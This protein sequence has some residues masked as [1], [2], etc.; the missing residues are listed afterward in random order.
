MSKTKTKK[1]KKKR[2]APERLELTWKLQDLPTAQHRAGLAGLVL[3]IQSL[4]SRSDGDP[5]A[6]PPDQVPE[7]VQ[8]TADGAVVGFTAT[9]VQRLMDDLYDASIVEQTVEK[10]WSGK[11]PKRE[12]EI[13]ETD[14]KTQKTKRS[15]RFIYDVYQPKG[16][17]LASRYPSMPEGSGW[18]KLWRDMIWSIPR[19]VPTTRAPYEQRAAASACKEGPAAW[20]ELV[21]AAS[22]TSSPATKPVSSSLWL[23]AQ[24]INAEG[25]D[26]LGQAGQNFLLHFWVL[27]VRVSVP[28]IIDNQGKS[29][30]KGYVLAFPEVADLESFVDDWPDTLGNLSTET[31]GYRPAAAVLDVPEQGALELLNS[32][33]ALKTAEQQRQPLREVNAVEFMHVEKPGNSVKLYAS[34]RVPAD[35]KLLREY[36][37]IVGEPGQ[38][39]NY[40][41]PLFR[42]ALMRS[43]LRREPWWR[44]LLPMFMT[45]DWRFF[46]NASDTSSEAPDIA[47][48][49]WFWTDVRRKLRVESENYKKEQDMDPNAEKAPRPLAMIINN[50]VRQYV[51]ER[52][53]AR[54]GVELPKEVDWEKVNPKFKEEQTHVAQSLF[55][56]F[57][58]RREQAFVDHFAQTLFA[59]KQYLSDKDQ[60]TLAQALTG[61]A[62]NDVK[63]LTLMALSANS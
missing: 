51:R 4:K 38:K 47:R 16:T 21:D 56:E 48:L 59:T 9:S 23:G 24:A 19:G 37:D 25:I 63:T 22:A 2:E 40:R 39:P 10:P 62:V 13:E 60:L 52:A 7:I 41:N 43:I 26:F 35:P 30:F 12:I 46:V 49:P 33:A 20:D 29:D 58:S 15:R 36:R 6:I 18:L 14:P 8:L 53:Q 1:Q 11:T 55:M 17:M 44:Q 28:N 32:I 3:L 34:G 45:Q 54:S 5:D 57:R 61:G 27:T 50:L 42:A 31:R